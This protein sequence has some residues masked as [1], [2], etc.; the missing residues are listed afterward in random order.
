VAHFTHFVLLQQEV[1]PSTNPN[2]LTSE[3]E[4]KPNSSGRQT[5]PQAK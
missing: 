5:T 1:F 2:Y 3:V 4:I